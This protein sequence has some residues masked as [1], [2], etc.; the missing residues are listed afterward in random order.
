[1]SNSET[2]VACFLQLCHL[3]FDL[4]LMSTYIWHPNTHR[5]ETF[6]V[7]CQL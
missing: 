4:K 5:C 6:I 2:M 1:M 7:V 3:H